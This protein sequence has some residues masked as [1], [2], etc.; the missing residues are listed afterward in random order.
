MDN[1]H[2]GLNRTGIDSM[3]RAT[4]AA[5]AHDASALISRL[6]GDLVSLVSSVL[7]VPLVPFGARRGK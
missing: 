3:T 1:S 7:L 6:H 5:N 4:T 2:T